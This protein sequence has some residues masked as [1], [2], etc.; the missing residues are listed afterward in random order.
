MPNFEYIVRTEDGK[1][2]EGKIDAKTLNE[3][4]EKLYEKKYTIVKLDE[5]EVAFEF[6]GPFLDRLSLSVEK[7]KNRIPLTTLV[8]FTRQLSTMF[9]AGLTLEKSIFFLSQE[10]KNPKFKKILGDIDK[11][12]KRGMLLSDGLERH[13]GV[14]SNLFISMARAGEVSGKLS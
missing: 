10:E 2:I 8:F 6:L 9:S 13:P 11:N 12:I 3:A 5:K 14:F 1:R 7:L 4:S